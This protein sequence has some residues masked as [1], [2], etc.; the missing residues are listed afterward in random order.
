MRMASSPVLGVDVGTS[1]ASTGSA[2]LSPAADEWRD[3]RFRVLDSSGPFDAAR[4]ADAIDHAARR[5]GA[6]AVSLDGPQG[7]RAPGSSCRG[8]GRQAEYSARCP[9]KTGEYGRTYPGTYV[10]WVRLCIDVFDLLL[11]RPGV[12]LAN[13]PKG[14]PPVGSGAYILL[15]ASPA[16]ALANSALLAVP[17][18]AF[19]WTPHSVGLLPYAGSTIYLAFRNVSDDRF[20]VLSD[21]VRVTCIL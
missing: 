13:D 14:A 15:D 20:L 11:S 3:C 5:H 12:V 7:W 10:R 8:V 17:R 4:L 9:G 18:E 1:W 2:L 21:H 19:A 6:A 16:G